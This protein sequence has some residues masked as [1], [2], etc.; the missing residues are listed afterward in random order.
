MQKRTFPLGQP[1][2]ISSQ[3]LAAGDDDD[4]M[5]RLLPS[6]F[7]LVFYVTLQKMLLF[8]GIETTRH[9]PPA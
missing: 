5:T 1:D 7:Q 3:A 4:P 8:L 2:A 6:I 9:F